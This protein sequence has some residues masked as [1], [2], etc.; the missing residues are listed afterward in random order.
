MEIILHHDELGWA[1]SHNRMSSCTPACDGCVSHK[2]L[3]L[4]FPELF[5]HLLSF[6]I[7]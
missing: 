5:F 3:N 4:K 1:T 2:P 7:R 6:V